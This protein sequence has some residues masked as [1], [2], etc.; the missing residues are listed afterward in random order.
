MNQFATYLLLDLFGTF[1]HQS[2]NCF[3]QNGSIISVNLVSTIFCLKQTIIGSKSIKEILNTKNGINLRKCWVSEDMK[4]QATICMTLHFQKVLII[5]SLFPDYFCY[6]AFILYIFHAVHQ[7]A[8]LA[9]FLLDKITCCFPFLLLP[10]PP[11]HLTPLPPIHLTDLN[12]P[13]MG[14]NEPQSNC[15]V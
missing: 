14:S 10:L 8:N 6:K 9:K 11:L 4:L 1:Q 13:R 3:F 2:N 12:G 5:F 7:H 15:P